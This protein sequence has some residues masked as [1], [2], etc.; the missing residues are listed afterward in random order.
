MIY[1]YYYLGFG[2]VFSL[3]C[4]TVNVLIRCFYKGKA[5]KRNG[6]N[7]VLIIIGWPLL[8]LFGAVFGLYWRLVGDE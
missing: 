1:V 2:L 6:L 4:D 8:L 7:F 3:F 5:N